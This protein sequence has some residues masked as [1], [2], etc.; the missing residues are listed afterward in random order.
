MCIGF[1]GL[2]TMGLPMALCLKEQG[3]DLQGWDQVPQAGASSPW[4]RDTLAAVAAHAEVLITMLPEGKDVAA[5]HD[6]VLSSGGPADRLFLDCSTIDVE[7][8]R[9]L[10]DAAAGAGHGFVDAPVSGGPEGARNG[11]LS[12]MVGGAPEHVNR[13]RPLL[14]VMGAKIT[15][16]GAP[17]AGQAAKAC[18][19]MICGITA[20]GVCEAF[21][22]AESL[23]LDSTSFY[24]LCQGAAAQSW[25]LENRCP[26]PGPAPLAPASN[27]YAPGFAAR[28]MAKDLRLAQAAA[29]A[30]GQQT[31]FGAEAARRF[32]AFAETGGGDFDFSA[33][34]RDIRKA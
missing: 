23:G 29:A 12:F 21:A 25:I 27:G 33:I 18:H 6:A 5:V 19:N 17:G 11:S 10:A 2:G 30:S 3:F 28:L 31:P 34:Y 9:R 15:E 8:T 26:V 20:L 32:T 16:F 14:A 22:L 7:T 24:Q 13:A 4:R 1:V